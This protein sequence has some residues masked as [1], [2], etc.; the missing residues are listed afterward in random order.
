[1]PRLMPPRRLTLPDSAGLARRRADARRSA[2]SAARNRAPI[3]DAVARFAP[4][5]GR[6]LELA[7]GTGEHMV[8]LARRLP[9]LEWQ[10]SDVDPEQRA[11]IRAW[12]AHA[13]LSDSV[14]PPIHLDATAPGWGARLAPRALIL[15]INLLHL[16]SAPEAET[17][18]AEAARAL[19]PGG[20]FLIYGPF[21]RGTEFA[22]EGDRRFHES[23]RA[24]DPEIGYKP[25]EWV[26]DA[27]CAAGLHP[28]PPVDMPANNLILPAR[29]PG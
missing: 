24:Q 27:Q 14:N 8:A 13:G 6:A 25:V 21:L 18:I 22:S 29:K 16:I 5:R 4:A 1:M 11:S 12:L 17:L 3:L 15:L 28:L 2:P 7:S 26:R 10:P 9:G 19:A 23:L 20:V